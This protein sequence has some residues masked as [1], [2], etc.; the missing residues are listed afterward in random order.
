MRYFV[1]LLLIAT[2]CTPPKRSDPANEEAAALSPAEAAKDQRMRQAEPAV[3]TQPKVIIDTIETTTPVETPPDTTYT[4]VQ[5]EN[6]PKERQLDS[7]VAY[8]YDSAGLDAYAATPDFNGS[9]GKVIGHLRFRSK[10]DLLTELK[11]D[12]E[13]EIV[14]KGMRGYYALIHFENRL[15]YVFSAYLLELPVPTRREGLINYLT[16]N[17]KLIKPAARKLVGTDKDYGAYTDYEFESGITVRTEQFYEDG[18]NFY[19]FPKMNV[20]QGYI[21]MRYFF[22]HFYKQVKTIPRKSIADTTGFPLRTKAKVAN[23]RVTS[24]KAL[25]DYFLE[26]IISKGDGIEIYDG[27]GS[28]FF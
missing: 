22:D 11:V 13:G 20:Q 7:L 23:G 8:V 21:F 5:F 18:N 26:Y 25:D 4:E 12:S 14:V 3:N 10:V 15:A 28:N 2:A 6:N 17:V 9:N 16:N 27:T 1:V 24:I 19:R